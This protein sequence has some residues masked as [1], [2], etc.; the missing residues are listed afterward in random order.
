M[1]LNQLRYFAKVAE[2]EHMTQ[3][4]RELNI[5][6][7]AL[8]RTIRQLEEELGTRLFERRGRNIVLT[9]SGAL[10][11]SRTYEITRHIGD[12]CAEVRDAHRVH[13]PVVMVARAAACLLPGMVHA[14]QGRYPDIAVSIIQNDNHV[15]TSQKYDL[16][17]S[18]TIMLP[19]RHS[20]A[21]LLD[22]PFRVLL[23]CGHPLAAQ[24]C[25][26]LKQLDGLPFISLTPNRFISVMLNQ[27][28]KTQGISVVRHVYSDDALMI[29][30]LVELGLGFSILPKFTFRA[31][32]KQNLC[33]LPISD[34]FPVL[35]LVLS[36]K[37][38]AYYPES[39]RRFRAFALSYFKILREQEKN[40][41][42][43][44][45]P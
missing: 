24:R 21:V 33:E 31:Q 14:F 17:L 8:S 3:A 26:A 9:E 27:A 40:R 2:L 22:N 41:E 4:A 42:K 34:P 11:L 25:V 36:W 38:N 13:Q 20:S 6:E 12:V 43:R 16:M 18:G 23:P 30:N 32:D 5:S 19:P 37:P 1:E 29:R 10:L 39:V 7:S 15:I 44:D 35:H 45:R 28:L